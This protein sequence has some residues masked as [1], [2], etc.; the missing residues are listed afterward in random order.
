MMPDRPKRSDQLP[1]EAPEEQVPDDTGGE[2]SGEHV[3]DAPDPAEPT[4]A[5]GNPKDD[6]RAE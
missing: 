6:P 5:T 2:G 4:P 1:E 3:D